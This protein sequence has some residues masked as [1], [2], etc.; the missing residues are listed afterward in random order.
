MNVLDLRVEKTWKLW[1]DQ[2]RFGAF[3]DVFNVTNQRV[4]LRIANFS[5]PNFGVPNQW[6]DPRTVRAGVR[7]MF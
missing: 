6:L 5:G 4:A 7:V 2:S 3:V 1:S